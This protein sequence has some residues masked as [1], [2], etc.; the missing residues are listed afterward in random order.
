MGTGNVI[1]T[2][3]SDQIILKAD[4]MESYQ[5]NLK[6]FGTIPLKTIDLQV[7]N[8]MEVY[9]VGKPIGIYVKTQGVLVIGIGDVKSQNGVL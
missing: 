8:D 9:P 7:V 6:L 3:P 4:K 5:V 2:A 1:K